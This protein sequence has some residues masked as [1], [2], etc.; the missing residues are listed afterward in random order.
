MSNINNILVFENIKF[1]ENKFI[2]IKNLKNKLWNHNTKNFFTFNYFCMLNILFPKKDLNSNKLWK[3]LDKKIK[4]KF[5][6][7][8]EICYKC[9]KNNKG[10]QTH[11]FCKWYYWL[12]QVVTCFYYTKEIKKYLLNFKYYHRKDILSEIWDMMDLYF[13]MYY[14]NL[15]KNKTLIT[16]V[17]M[18]WIRKYFIKWY[19]QWKLLANYIWRKNNVKVQ[20]VCKKIKWTKPQAK[21]KDRKER[22]ENLKDSFE[23]LKISEDVEAIVIVDDILTTW[24]TLEEFSKLI[25]NKY[26]KIKIYWLVLARK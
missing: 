7:H 13:K 22:L 2:E 3:Y 12:E 17:S 20:Q 23:L 10:F 19:N 6:P 24:S 26:P 18:H 11:N 8:D 9:K 14:S 5:Q 1:F 16:Y 4:F 15:N 25:K 21:V